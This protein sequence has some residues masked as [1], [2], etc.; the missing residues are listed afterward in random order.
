MTTYTVEIER[1]E[2][3]YWIA[4]F[5]DVP[6]CHT[7]A[8]TATE[9][10]DRARQ[11]LGDFVDDADDAVLELDLVEIPDRTRQSLAN[12]LATRDSSRVDETRRQRDLAVAARDLQERGYS[13]RD[14]ATI[15]GLSHGRIQQLLQILDRDGFVDPQPV[16]RIRVKPPSPIG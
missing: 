13:L 3:G 16:E 15:V 10:L 4:D 6:G 1:D 9:L 14:I 12:Y 8:R 7:Q 5:V 2:D 11:I